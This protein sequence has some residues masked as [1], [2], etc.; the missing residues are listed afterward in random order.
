[1]SDMTIRNPA[2]M[3]RFADEIDEYCTS[4][5]SVCNELKSGLSSAESMMK[6]DQ[7]KKALRRFETLAEELI[8][9]L[10]EA[11]EAAEKLRAAAKP[12]D[13]ALSLNI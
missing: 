8:K 12:L 10:P 7:S 4:M 13:S 5:K 2:D 11:Q 3:K 1:M 6:D 9:G